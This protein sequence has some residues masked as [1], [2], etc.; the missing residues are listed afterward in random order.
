[1][2]GSEEQWS[3]WS[4]ER[5]ARPSR[6]REWE[7]ILV[8]ILIGIIGG[9]SGMVAYLGREQRG[10]ATGSGSGEQQQTGKWC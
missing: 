10:F 2:D 5:W 4:W 6:R 8:V 3:E 7:Q 9:S 1:M